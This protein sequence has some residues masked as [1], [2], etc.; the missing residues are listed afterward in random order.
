MVVWGGGGGVGVVCDTWWWCGVVDGGSAGVRA[1]AGGG[2]VGV[3]D[4]GRRQVRNTVPGARRCPLV[5]TI[6]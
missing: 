5:L 3:E 2:E 6:K 4:G 1:V